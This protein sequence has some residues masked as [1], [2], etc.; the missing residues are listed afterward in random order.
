MFGLTDFLADIAL[1][2]MEI[3]SY[4][5]SILDMFVSNIILVVLFGI[6]VCG[7]AIGLTMRVVHRR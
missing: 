5:G 7:A 2:V 6:M 3:M 1:V 4:F